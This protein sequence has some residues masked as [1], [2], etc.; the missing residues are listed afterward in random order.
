MA[1]EF[2]YKDD[3][4][5]ETDEDEDDEDENE[6]EEVLEIEMNNYEIDDFIESLQNLK[7]EKGSLAFGFDGFKLVI[8]HSEE[9]E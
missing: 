2:E 9:E 5:D 7:K 6:E 1:V 4:S 8:S 3:E